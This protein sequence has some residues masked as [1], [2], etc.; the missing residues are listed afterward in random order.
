MRVLV[1][2][3]SKHG[4]TREIAEH[5]AATLRS[6]GHAADARPVKD[7]RDPERYDA[8]VVGSAIFY[9]SWM[10]EATNFARRHANLLAERPTWLFSSGPLGRELLDD[11]G[12]DLR[13]AAKPKQIDEL[14]ELLAPRGH[15][16]FFGALRRDTFSFCERLIAALPAGKE[17]F[18]EGDFRDWEDIEH[19]ARRIA[20]ALTPT[21]A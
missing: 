9:G 15:R 13:E 18:P 21:M 3:A 8:F 16:V 5:L 7:V 14:I 17:L 20:A 12:R 6:A 1:A 11:E 4:A 2:Y 10:K 19:W